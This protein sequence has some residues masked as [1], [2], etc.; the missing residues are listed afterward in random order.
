MSIIT[1]LKTFNQIYPIFI[2]KYETYIPSEEDS[3]V[4]EKLNSMIQYLNKIGHLNNEVVS[5]WNKVMEW[6]LKDGLSAVANVEIVK[7]LAIMEQEGLLKGDKGDVGLQGLQ[8]VQ[9]EQ[10]EQGVQGEKGVSGDIASQESLNTINQQLAE[11]F[12]KTFVKSNSDRVP[13][14]SLV[15]ERILKPLVTFIDDDGSNQIM[16]KLKPI[17]DAK[18][19]KFVAALVGDSI[20]GEVANG[21]TLAQAKDLQDNKGWEIASHSYSHYG[22]GEVG[23]TPEILEYELRGSL[24]YFR[25]VGLNVKNYVYP[26]GQY[27][28]TVI[29]LVAKY[30]NSGISTDPTINKAPMRMYKLGRIA[31]PQ[32]APNNTLAWYKAKVDEAVTN[33]SWLIWML[34]C[35]DETLDATQLQHLSALIDYIK[36]LNVDIVTSQEGLDRVGNIVSINDNK[37]YMDASGNNNMYNYLPV[38]FNSQTGIENIT[39]SMLPSQFEL[40]KT[41]TAQIV[42]TT[43]KAKFPSNLAG[44]FTVVMTDVASRSY[45]RFIDANGHEFVRFAGATDVWG[46]WKHMSTDFGRKS[47][48]FT[49]AVT[50]PAN[51]YFKKSISL[52]AYTLGRFTLVKPQVAL[53]TGLTFTSYTAGLDGAIH[54]MLQNFTASPIVLTDTI[55]DYM[56]FDSVT[57]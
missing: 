4:T 27:N 6:M 23:A 12:D 22:A 56:V 29:R 13:T 3:G 24:E 50:V 36:G 11:T 1:T 8:G 37:F 48:T 28:D 18:G 30:Y 49:G 42:T 47:I 7:V 25:S 5:N 35:G 32:P 55:W 26:G 14:L 33:N 20:E 19:V 46:A 2:Q 9:G 31:F 52:G 54:V 51:S 21:L 34:H 40:N 38:K 10:G 15:T 44:V 57:F 39:A 45:Q 16:T 53:P 17:T 43:E 41:F